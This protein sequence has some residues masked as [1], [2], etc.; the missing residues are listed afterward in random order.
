MKIQ[1]LS[2]IKCIDNESVQKLS[3]VKGDFQFTISGNGNA[4]IIHSGKFK[5]EPL[6]NPELIIT[7]K[8]KRR[9]IKQL[10]TLKAL[11]SLLFWAHNEVYPPTSDML[12]GFHQ[13]IIKMTGIMRIDP[14][15]GEYVLISTSSPMCTT[16]DMNRFIN[17]AFILLIE[18][19]LP[20]DMIDP[21]T[22]RNLPQ[23]FHEWYLNITSETYPLDVISSWNRYLQEFPYDEFNGKYISER[24]TGL[25]EQIHILSRGAY[26]EFSKCPWNWIHGSTYIHRRI[27]NEGWSPIIKDYPHMKN[28]VITAYKKAGIEFKE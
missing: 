15:C 5:F 12:Y 7:K 22:Q 26:P 23:I 20:D 28:K 25:T 21:V 24:G 4:G 3:R 13:I 17:T 1:P 27:H 11:E 18:S 8:I 9:T 19:D 10:K 16:K 14:S 2:E 6:D